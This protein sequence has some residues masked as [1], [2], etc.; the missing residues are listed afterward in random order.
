[1]TRHDWGE[2]H[3]WLGI[4]FLVG[5]AVHLVLNWNWLTKIA[6]Q[7]HAWRLWLGLLAGLALLILPLATPVEPS[8]GER[9]AGSREER[10]KG[11]NR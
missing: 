7:K 1:M 3:L 11:K 10:G 8:T 5:I 4:A 6:A 2:I 9:G